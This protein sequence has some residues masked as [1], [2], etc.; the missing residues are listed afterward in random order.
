M[1]AVASALL[2]AAATLALVVPASGR[3][4]ARVASR[5]RP[6][7]RSWATAWSKAWVNASGRAR[8]R[9]LR[10]RSLEA[11]E[12]A[13]VELAQALSA[14]LSAG[15]PPQVAVR[16]ACEGLA[17]PALLVAVGPVL[18]AAGRGADVGGAMAR[19]A[20]ADGCA[21][22]RWAAVAWQVCEETGS[23]LAVAL[24]RVAGSARAQAEHRRAVRAALAGPRAT[25]R[26]LAVLPFV[27]LGLGSA[28]GSNPVAVLVGTPWGLGCLLTGLGLELAGLR[29]TA[30]LA[31][32]AERSA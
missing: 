1:T 31:R 17:D 20:L 30:R 4:F 14:E 21:A 12:S 9:L 16:S 3:S 28:L 10:T 19:A 22:L 5:T 18:E 25:A 2:A 26:L 15:R 29:W 24:D 32:Q 27:G 8:R 7:R 23:G 13:V 11:T 6:P